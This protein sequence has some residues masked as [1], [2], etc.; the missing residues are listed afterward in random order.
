M[1]VKSLI[2]SVVKEVRVQDSALHHPVPNAPIHPELLD[3]LADRVESFM[4]CERTNETLSMSDWD[5]GPL[6][7]RGFEIET[8]GSVWV[9]IDPAWKG[10]PDV[11]EEVLGLRIGGGRELTLSKVKEAIDSFLAE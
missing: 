3:N 7:Y 1:S 4:R 6:T 5:N 11:C 10:Q 9:W 2:V 8:S